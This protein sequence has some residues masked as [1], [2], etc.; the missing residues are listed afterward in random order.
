MIALGIE[1]GN[2]KQ[3][4]RTAAIHCEDSIDWLLDFI[5]GL[6]AKELRH[7]DAR[8][9]VFDNKAQMHAIAFRVIARTTNYTA[10]SRNSKGVF[11]NFD[12]E[13]H[14]AFLALL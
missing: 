5:T 1:S 14:G 11:R 6:V 4:Q 8:L 12:C 13:E 7:C 3:S 2:T 9:F 10:C